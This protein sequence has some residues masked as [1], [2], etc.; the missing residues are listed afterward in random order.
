MDGRTDGWPERRG[1]LQYR[2]FFFEK[3]GYNNVDWVVKLKLKSHK[4]FFVLFTSLIFY[5]CLNILFRSLNV[6]VWFYLKDGQG[7]SNS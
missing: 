1:I 6:V 4:A 7:S 3:R 2:R 5:L